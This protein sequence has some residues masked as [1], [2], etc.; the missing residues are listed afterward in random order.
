MKRYYL[1]VCTVILILFLVFG[2]APMLF[3]AKSDLGVLAALAVIFFVVPTVAA[4]SFKK[5]KKWGVKK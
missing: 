4:F 2:L 1:V 5:F 3:S